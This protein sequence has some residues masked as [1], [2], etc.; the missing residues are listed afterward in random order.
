MSMTMNGFRPVREFTTLRD[1]MDR[2]F[3]DSFV[4][5]GSWH[6]L[7]GNGARYLPIDLYETPDAFVLRAH[8]PGVTPDAL[9]VNYQQGI[10]TLRATT[11]APDVQESWRWYAR[12]IGA[13]EVTR[14]ISLPRQIDV[15]HVQAHFEN[16][17][18]TLNLPKSDE[19]KPRRIAIQGSASGYEA[20]PQQ[21]ESGSN[22]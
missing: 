5:P 10:L 14:Q 2:L 17:V 16:G 22:T 21:I 12:E 6:S 8:V 3:E 20:Q 19:A 1:A 9:E 18:L 13:G 7:S 4:N 11:P 15:E